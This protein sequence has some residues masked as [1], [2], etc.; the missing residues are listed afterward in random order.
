MMRQCIR[1]GYHWRLRPFINNEEHF[2]G[3]M[4]GSWD[5]CRSFLDICRIKVGGVSMFYYQ[6]TLVTWFYG[7]DLVRFENKSY[8]GRRLEIV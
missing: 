6:A 3:E 4:M 1:T 8:G 2:V 7:L 5:R